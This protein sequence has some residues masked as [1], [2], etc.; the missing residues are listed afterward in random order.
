[1]TIAPE[2]RYEFEEGAPTTT[3]EVP[4]ATDPGYLERLDRARDQASRP[5][6]SWLERRS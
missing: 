2:I 5:S 6:A 4:A 3:T 1:M